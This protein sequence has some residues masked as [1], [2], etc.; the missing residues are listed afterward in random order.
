MKKTT[1]ETKESISFIPMTTMIYEAW[2]LKKKRLL[3]E[4][5]FVLIDRQILFLSKMV[6]KKVFCMK[7]KKQWYLNEKN[8]F[9]VPNQEKKKGYYENPCL[10][11][12]TVEF[13]F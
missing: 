8:E 4:S 3:Q 11:Q 7:P 12:L 6:N 10:S 2:S 9:M 1:Y 5:L 13:G